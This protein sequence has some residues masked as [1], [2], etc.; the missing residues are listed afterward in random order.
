[1]E[2]LL[3]QAKA[4]S[5]EDQKVFFR[6]FIESMTVGQILPLVKELEEEWDVEA[7]PQFPGTGTVQPE[8]E[9]KEQTEFD[10]IVTDNGAKRIS[11]VKALKGPANMLLKEASD[12]LKQLPA[13]VMTKVSKERADEAK[14]LLEE[15]G[16]TVEIR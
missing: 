8:E 10:V 6:K 14:K 7:T 12:L 13:T 4:L 15:A 16:A 3:D 1:M 5:D 11:V 2:A 9:E